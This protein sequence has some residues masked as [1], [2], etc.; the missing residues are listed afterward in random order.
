MAQF[1]SLYLD[2]Y[3]SLPYMDMPVNVSSD[4]DMVS[5]DF[6]YIF[7]ISQTPNQTHSYIF[8]IGFVV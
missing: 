7:F 1:T 4:I 6:E 3:C 8:A 2:F 5:I